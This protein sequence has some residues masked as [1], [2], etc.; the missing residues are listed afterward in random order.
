MVRKAA[1]PQAPS[2]VPILTVKHS[3]VEDGHLELTRDGLLHL[4]QECG[5]SVPDDADVSAEIFCGDEY[6]R[7]DVYG[8]SSII[9]TWK[10]TTP[11]SETRDE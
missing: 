10:K 1:Q 8:N 6:A 9:V 4:L 5:Y 2:K 11:V 7:G 3:Q